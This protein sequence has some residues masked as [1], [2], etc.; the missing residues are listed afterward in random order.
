MHNNRSAMS[1][2]GQSRKLARLNGMSIN[3]RHRATASACP[4]RAN[5]GL[6]PLGLGSAS[7]HV[8]LGDPASRVRLSRQDEIGRINGR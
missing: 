8:W 3:S 4:F 1:Q 6:M 5:S 2:L 7:C